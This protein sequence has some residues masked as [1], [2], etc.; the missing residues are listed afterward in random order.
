M[1][2]HNY[3]NNTVQRR[4]ILEKKDKST[5]NSWLFVQHRFFMPGSKFAGSYLFSYK[6]YLLNVAIHLPHLQKVGL[7]FNRCQR[8]SPD[9]AREL[10]WGSG[11]HLSG[12]RSLHYPDHT[13]QESHVGPRHAAA[14]PHVHGLWLHGP[15]GKPHCIRHVLWHIIRNDS[16]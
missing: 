12:R 13:K 11:C 2:F 15:A 3:R 16:F 10:P 7:V 1:R 8:S 5:F 14:H 6:Y 4:N 9:Q